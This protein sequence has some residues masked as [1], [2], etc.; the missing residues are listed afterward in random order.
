M[1][2][3]YFDSEE[4]ME[5]L[6]LLA[7]KYPSIQEVC[8]EL[9]NLQAILNLPKGTEHFMSD[10]HGEYEAFYHILNNCSGVIR[11]KV[12]L[13]FKELLSKEEQSELCTLIYY[14]EEKL[15]RIREEG[16]NTPEWYRFILQCLISLT[17]LLSS[18]YTRSK[19]R[20]AMPKEYSYIIDELLHAQQDEDNSQVVYHNKIIDTLIGLNNG[21]D[22]IIALTTLIKRL[23]VDHLHI[24]GDIFDRGARPDTIIDYLMQQYSLDIEWGNHD[25]LWMGAAAGSEAC[26]ATVV[27]NCLSYKNMSV[28]ERGYGISLRRLVLFAEKTYPEF[29]DPTKAALFAISIILFKLEGQAIMRNPDF[30]LQ[31]RLYLKYINYDTNEI[32]IDGNT[33][34][35]E[36]PYFH[37]ID[38]NDPYKL[39]EEEKHTITELKASF[40][41]SERLHKHVQFLYEKGSLYRIFNENLL[42]HGCIPLDENGDF[43][44]IILRG[45]AYKGKEYMDFA[46]KV[47]RKAYFDQPSLENLDFMWYLW[48]GNYSPLSGRIVKTFERMFIEKEE[49]WEEPQNSYYKYCNTEK[50]CHMILREFG[51]FSSV[52]HIINGHTP[53]RV[54]EGESPIKANGKLL[55]IDGGFCKTYQKKTGIAGYTLI[56]NSHGL[57]LMSHQPFISMENSLEENTDIE[58]Q[59]FVVETEKYRVMVND[60]DT[61]KNLKKQIEELKQLLTA[62]R[63]GFLVP[64]SGELLYRYRIG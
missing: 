58:S 17:K 50:T 53:V 46:D 52:S 19:V 32:T 47:A 9:I 28:L 35:L 1:G 15:H 6:K 21:D 18:K 59:S 61:G 55:V 42:F 54:I 31:N 44:S 23:A 14:P 2:D 22:I 45:K 40:H 10:L 26:I 64:K 16:K 12:Q 60:T 8:T 24:V 13:L 33:Y 11:E 30:H 57:R 29:P 63:Q 48:C 36:T 49:L 41:E 4:H 39:T 7:E 51:L 62:Y 27:R 5:F 38:R 34:Q 43:E 20:K 37:T 3:F 25:I 56:Y